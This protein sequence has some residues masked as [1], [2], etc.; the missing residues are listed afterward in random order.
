M[1]AKIMTG[2]QQSSFSAMNTNHPQTWWHVTDCQ[3]DSK[4][5]RFFDLSAFVEG[6]I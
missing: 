3:K 6:W 5:V 1:L 2:K 4:N